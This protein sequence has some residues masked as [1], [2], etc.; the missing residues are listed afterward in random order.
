MHSFITQQSEINL[1]AAE[2]DLTFRCLRYLT[3]DFFRR[4][5]SDQKLQEHIFRGDLGFQDYAVSQW[6]MHMQTFV[7]AKEAFLEGHTMSVPTAERSSTDQ[8]TLVFRELHNFV[9]FYE[10]SLS[11]QG[12]TVPA[13]LAAGCAFFQSYPF[14][15]LLTSIW[16]H[17]CMS[18]RGD[19]QARN[20]VSLDLLEETLQRNRCQM[21]RF[22]SDH[23]LDF[24]AVYD[25]Y[26]FRCPKV[27]C[28]Y[29]HE[30]FKSGSF[31]DNHVNHHDLPFHCSV[32]N[33][34]SHMSGFRSNNE[35]R[36]HMERYHPEDSD[37]EESFEVL[38]RAPVARTRWHCEPCDLYFV[39]KNILEDHKRSHRGEKPFCCSECGRGFARKS[40]MKRH[41]QI[42]E[43]RRRR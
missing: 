9:K 13:G 19:F 36:K 2:C 38:N 33:C 11:V 41:E 34:S 12:M 35:L 21:E 14:Y 24:S 40:D 29:F 37:L 4:D 10:T 5:I 42:H 25:E 28:F 17:I 30:G 1:S 23:R 26:P 15:G 16:N 22:G 8:A 18:Q 31:R 3:L 32:E 20:K 39:R 43:K 7:E 27:L 6:Y